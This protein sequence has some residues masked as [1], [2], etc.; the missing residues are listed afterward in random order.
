MVYM[1]TEEVQKLIREGKLKE[2]LLIA[3]KFRRTFSGITNTELKQ[4]QLGYGCLTNGNF[5]K[6]LNYN[7]L[8]EIKEAEE[9]LVKVYGGKDKMEREI[10]IKEQLDTLLEYIPRTTILAEEII[11]ILGLTS[12]DDKNILL[13]L[14]KDYINKGILEKNR[15]GIYNEGGIN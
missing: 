3:G 4:L 11:T 12:A 10:K 15:F 14:I 2:A 9:I 7:I 5:Y 13:N 8:L 1:K 6:Q